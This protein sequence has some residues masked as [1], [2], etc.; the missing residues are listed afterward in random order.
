MID[1]FLDLEGDDIQ[2]TQEVLKSAVRNKQWGVDIVTLLL[3]RGDHV[4]ITPEVFMS[5][6]ENLES[7]KDIMALLHSR[8]QEE[9][10]T[11]HSETASFREVGKWT[12][13]I[14]DHFIALGLYFHAIGKAI[15][16]N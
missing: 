5:A 6:A 3:N 2:I 9:V 7:G 11:S 8:R 16:V 1:W 15:E 4:K 13:Q 10:L 14:H 12:M